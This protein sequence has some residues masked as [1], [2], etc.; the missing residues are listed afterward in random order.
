[1]KWNSG[2][3]KDSY[4]IKLSVLD[5]CVI[6]NRT[7][8]NKKIPKRFE[9]T[10][11]NIINDYSKMNEEFKKKHGRYFNCSVSIGKNNGESIT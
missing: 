1:M 10:L 8:N 11:L 7:A 5:C 9:D 6:L 3:Q 4:I 2:R